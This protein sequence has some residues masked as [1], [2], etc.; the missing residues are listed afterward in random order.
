MRFRAQEEMNSILG[1]HLSLS[2]TVRS[3][4]AWVSLSLSLLTNR[5]KT[6]SL[7]L[8]PSRF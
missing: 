3:T 2:R 5:L 4:G 6:L 1:R 8:Y 7:K